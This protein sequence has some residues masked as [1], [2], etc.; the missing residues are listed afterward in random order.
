MRSMAYAVAVLAAVGM[1]VGI[2]MMPGE[3]TPGVELTPVAEA[4]S[5]APDVKQEAGTL[6]MRV[7]QMHCPFA[8][9]PA[10]KST[11]E[12]ESGIASVEL[13]E[14]K[15]EGVIDNPEVVIQYESGF[16]VNSAIAALAKKGFTKS[17]IVQ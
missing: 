14:Q 6:V 4:V 17:E 1:I 16:D 12:Q 10:V 11:L 7:P 8:C 2:A 15:E 3:S 9:Y 13:A 5:V